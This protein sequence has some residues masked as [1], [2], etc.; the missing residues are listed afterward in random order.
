MW[1]QDAAGDRIDRHVDRPRSSVGGGMLNLVFGHPIRL[2]FETLVG[3]SPEF[4]HS[5][6]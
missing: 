1:C 4:G 6:R 5:G 2:E 3:H